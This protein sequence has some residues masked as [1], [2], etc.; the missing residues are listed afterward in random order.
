MSNKKWTSTDE[1]KRLCEIWLKDPL[2]NPQTGHNIDRNGPT[3]IFWK[4]KCKE[5]GLRSRPLATKEIT[6][7]KCQEWKSNPEIN[8]DTGKKIKIGGRTYKWLEKQCKLITE[9]EIKLLGEYYLPDK[10]GMVPCIL[11]NKI[12]YITRDYD[13]RKVWGPL[14]KPAKNIKLQYFKDTWDYKNN[15]YKPIFLDNEPSNKVSKNKKIEKKTKYNILTKKKNKETK[16]IVD[17]I[18]DL[19][20]DKQ[21]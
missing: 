3:F 5:L 15:Y 9:K 17:N 20:M 7:R 19:F 21:K 1:L 4:E 13:N 16:Y 8:P 10:N 2:V 18:L 14:N 11:S 6:W 12:V